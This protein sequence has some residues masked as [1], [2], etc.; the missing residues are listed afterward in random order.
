MTKTLGFLVTAQCPRM[1]FPIQV[2]TKTLG[3]RVTAECPRNHWK[4]ANSR[5]RSLQ[6]RLGLLG[7]TQKRQ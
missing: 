3:F 4:I 6:I 5:F 7:M 1:G 2:V